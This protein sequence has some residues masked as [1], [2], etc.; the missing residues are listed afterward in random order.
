MP[1]RI[2]LNQELDII[3]LQSFGDT[4]G[5]EI[6]NSI[7]QIL[8]IRQASGVNRLLVDTTQ[9]ESMPSTIDLL[10][11]FSAYPRDLKT[12]LLV[13]KFQATVDDVEFVETVGVNRG[14]N[15]QMHYDRE[16]ALRWLNS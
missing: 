10:E 4:T 13:D 15:M 2:R 6:A 16:K 9:L 7:Q 3:E 5:V 12:A 11:I 1:D 14:K 8:E